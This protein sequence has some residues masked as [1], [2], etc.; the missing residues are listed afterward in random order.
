MHGNSAV[1][2]YNLYTNLYMHIIY[3]VHSIDGVMAKM[4]DGTWLHMLWKV[5]WIN[6][7]YLLSKTN[8]DVENLF[9]IT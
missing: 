4:Y 1:Y 3:L 2:K 5:V 7:N 8:L 9:V 6:I